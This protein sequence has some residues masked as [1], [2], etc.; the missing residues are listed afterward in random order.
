MKG[1]L[2]FI[3]PI[4]ILIGVLFAAYTVLLSPKPAAAKPK[5]AGTL[6]PLTNPFIVN[7]AGARYAKLSVR[8]S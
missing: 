6:V 7:L 3:A 4:P 1:K 5:I 8:C 2:K